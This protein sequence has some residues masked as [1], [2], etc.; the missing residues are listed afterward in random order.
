M[1]CRGYATEA[2]LLQYIELY[3]QSL[4]SDPDIPMWRNIH[5]IY[6]TEKISNIN[7][8]MLY[9]FRH[10]LWICYDLPAFAIYVPSILYQY[11]NNIV[12]ILYYPLV[13]RTFFKTCVFLVQLSWTNTGYGV[14][15]HMYKLCYAVAMPVSH[16]LSWNI[17]KHLTCHS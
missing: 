15:R 10:I 1:L 16:Q 11:A 9:P 4:G 13:S 7:C 17:L 3:N 2:L 12:T 6:Y 5:I 14:G 8:S